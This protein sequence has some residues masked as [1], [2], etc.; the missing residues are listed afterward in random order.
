MYWK[1]L[2]ATCFGLGWLPVAPGTWGSLPPAIVFGV[3][4]YLCVPGI[5]TT[6][7]MAVLTVVGCVACICCAPASIA[8]TGW[9][10]PG[11]VVMD[12]FAAQ[13]LTFLA[14]PLLVPRNLCGWESL[15]IAAFGFLMFRLFDIVKPGPIRRLE[16]LPA[17][18]GVLADDLV[19]GAASA[20]FVHIA[21]ILV[22]RG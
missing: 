8:V 17:G 7:V 15:V 4:M 13:A 2:I 5:A 11:E 1:R 19:A 20:V 10:D 14:V 22:V 16:R 12:E 21:M 6:I 9:Q 18:W 3:L